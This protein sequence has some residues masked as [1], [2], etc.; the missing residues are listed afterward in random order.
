M[1][2]C[3]LSNKYKK[4]NYQINLIDLSS[5]LS[6]ILSGTFFVIVLSQRT[7]FTDVLCLMTNNIPE[8]SVHLSECLRCMVEH[9]V[10]GPVDTIQRDIFNNNNLKH[11]VWMTFTCVSPVF[12]AYTHRC[13][14][15]VTLG[16]R[17]KVKTSGSRCRLSWQSRRIKMTHACNFNWKSPGQTSCTMKVM[18]KCNDFVI[19]VNRHDE[20]VR[21]HTLLLMSYTVNKEFAIHGWLTDCYC[22]G[23]CVSETVNI[24]TVVGRDYRAKHHSLSFPLL[25]FVMKRVC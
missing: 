11:L 5:L 2:S 8:L 13:L 1:F 15:V 25:I 18:R 16:L 17:K 22:S 3:N 6:K 23:W 10:A 14:F 20:K 7:D 24:S 4:K 9:P 21:S 19:Y 12:T